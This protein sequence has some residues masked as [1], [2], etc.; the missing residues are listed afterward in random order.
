MVASIRFKY[1]LTVFPSDLY[2]NRCSINHDF[3]V[4]L[5]KFSILWC[6][7]SRWYECKA[8]ICILFHYFDFLS[9]KVKF[10]F[11]Y[12]C[13]L[14]F[15]LDLTL[16]PIR[17]YIVLVLIFFFASPPLA[18][19]KLLSHLQTIICLF[20]YGMSFTVSKDRLSSSNRPGKSIM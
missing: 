5:I 6:F 10:K 7:F 2:K 14:F 4:L 1:V 8:Q 18:V 13:S 15:C 16:I 9:L 11:P 12:S 20:W 19:K 3:F 17:Y